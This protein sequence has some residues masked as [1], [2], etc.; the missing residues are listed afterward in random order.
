MTGLECGKREVTIKLNR[1]Y[2]SSRMLCDYSKE[3][4]TD[5]LPRTVLTSSKC[6][7]FW[8]GKRLTRRGFE[9]EHAHVGDNVAIVKIGVGHVGE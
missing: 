3:V 9:A 1:D 7:V 5:P 4:S 2:I 8:K 6:D